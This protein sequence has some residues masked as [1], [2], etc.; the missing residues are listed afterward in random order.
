MNDAKQHFN[1]R[2]GRFGRVRRG[3]LNA[4]LAYGTGAMAL[5]VGIAALFLLCGWTANPFVNGVLTLAATGVL[6]FLAARLWRRWEKRRT[7]L[8]E[9]FHLEALAGDLNSRVISAV[10]FI[11]WPAPTPLTEAVVRRARVDLERPFEGQLDRIAR[12]RLRLRFA[13]LLVVFLALGA[14]DR[15]GFVRMGRTV[16]QCA[17]NLREVL[18]P[19]RFE[20]LPGQGR[21]V[22]R[23]GDKVAAGIRFTRFG[24]PQVTMLQ[25]AADGQG[26]TRTVLPV[27]ADRT[28]G[29]TLQPAVAQ[30]V[31]MRFAFGNRLTEEM[32]LVFA[33]AP[34]IENMQVELVYPAY[35]R[36]VPKETEGIQDRITALAGTRVSL[37]FSFSKTLASAVLTFDDGERIPLDV[38]GRFASVSLVHSLERR[39]TLQVEDVHGFALDAPHA[40]EFSVT[41]DTPP[42]LIVP[43]YLRQD[44]PCLAED[45]GGFGF[46]VRVEDDFGAAKCVLKW[47]KSTVDEKDRETEKGEIEY[48]ILPPRTMAV[49]AFENIFRE[50]PGVPGDLYTFQIQAFDNRDP[51]PQS[52]V[53]ALFSVFLHQPGLETSMPGAG[54]DIM[55]GIKI[56]STARRQYGA[57]A[58]QLGVAL[59]SALKTTEKYVN[60][61]EGDRTTAVGRE[62]VRGA[63]AEATS[64]FVE[65]FSGAGK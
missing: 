29:V 25:T 51:K 53:S 11:Q 38:V 48:P 49:V 35:T 23:L 4:T 36:L 16:G 27:A 58:E 63:H 19:T 14:T 1:E 20:L 55:A 17:V 56:R 37:G 2:L 28:A 5:G 46:G 21:H 57:A 15:F 52:A 32:N 13:L 9:A 39:A 33:A 8:S 10:D 62:V 40:I 18:F 47:R 24:Y 50:H 60:A 65:A 45:L 43:N 7:V 30:E 61:F 12:N 42:R 54:T 64:K 22:Y 3:L 6:A 44:M 41:T 31:R 59:P 26:A 34:V